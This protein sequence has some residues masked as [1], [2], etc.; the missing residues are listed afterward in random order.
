MAGDDESRERLEHENQQLRQRVS[1]LERQL[2]R[3]DGER[4]AELGAGL[5][6]RLA[7]WQEAER[8]SHL[9]T[10]LWNLSTNEVRW[11]D[12]L[13]RILGYDPDVDPSNSEAFFARVHPDDRDRVAQV[14]RA[15]V[16]SGIS[17]QVDFRILWPDGTIRH[18]SMSGALLF[19]AG[20]TLVRAVGTIHDLTDERATAAELRARKQVLDEVARAVGVGWFRYDVRTSELTGSLERVLGLSAPT[21]LDLAGVAERVLPSDRDRAVARWQSVLAGGEV[22]PFQL[23]VLRAGDRLGHLYV[24]PT[25]EYDAGA[26]VVVRGV[27]VDVSERVELE[28]RLRQTEKMDVL[29]QVTAG[30]A[31]DF[32]NLLTVILCNT[33]RIG[34]GRGDEA[35][36]YIESAAQSAAHLTRRLLAFSRQAV[37]EPREVEAAQALEECLAIVGRTFEDHIVIEQT[38]ATEQTTVCIDPGQ[39]QQ[40]LLNLT[41]NARDAMAVGGGTLRTGCDRVTVDAT[42]AAAHGATPGD[43]IRIRVED[44]GV[45]MSEAHLARIFEPFFTTKEPGKGT[46]LGLATVF[47]AVRQSDG[48]LEVRSKLGVGTTFE[49]F[50]PVAIPTQLADAR[51]AKAVSGDPRRI[52]LV[53]DEPDV[54]TSVARMLRGFGHEVTACTTPSGGIDAWRQA[55]GYELL[56]TDYLMPEMTGIQLTERLRADRPELPV[57]I[58]SGWGYEGDRVTALER[59]QALPKPFTGEELLQAVSRVTSPT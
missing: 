56:I 45:G 5:S 37:V 58:L 15:G 10:W 42:R 21:T 43:F 47:G 59:A 40:I 52:L 25:V 50:L 46:G 36:D 57:L 17:E 20:G 18:V 27:V 48:F 30:V 55:G 28:A 13:Y 22:S 3:F 9:G 1:E 19:D 31:H 7:L 44:T 4:T 54:A 39:L 53:E 24:V 11:S 49:V 12:E 6:E 23:C 51:T 34:G 32:N 29:G 33:A 14:S 16:E 2:G 26:P 38:P 41:V 35:V 8:I